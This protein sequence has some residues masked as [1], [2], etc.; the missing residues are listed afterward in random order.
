MRG[1]RESIVPEPVRQAI[2]GV[3]VFAIGTE[4]RPGLSGRGARPVVRHV[5][6]A[7]VRALELPGAAG[8][9]E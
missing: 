5:G 2:S 1:F 8:S 9:E 6:P 4:G 7:A 3:K